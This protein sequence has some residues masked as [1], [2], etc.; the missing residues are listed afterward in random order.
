MWTPRF[1]FCLILVL[2]NLVASNRATLAPP[3][4]CAKEL[5]KSSVTVRGLLQIACYQAPPNS[6]QWKKAFILMPMSGGCIVQVEAAKERLAP[7]NGYIVDLVG[8]VR[9]GVPMGLF[10]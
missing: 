10:V 7:C 8:P 1:L 9:Y 2:T 3:C 5:P 6:Q 4:E